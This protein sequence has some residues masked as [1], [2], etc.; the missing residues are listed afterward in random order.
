MVSK[1]DV[2]FVGAT[3]TSLQSRKRQ[4]SGQTDLGHDDQRLAASSGGA[5]TSTKKTALGDWPWAA[6]EEE[7][8]QKPECKQQ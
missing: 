7:E 1:P 8:E 4:F 3:T 6:V 2:S 5:A